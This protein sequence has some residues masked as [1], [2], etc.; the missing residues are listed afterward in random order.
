[1]EKLLHTNTPR[2]A[3]TLKRA[4]TQYLLAD[5]PEVKRD[6]LRHTPGLRSPAVCAI[7]CEQIEAE[8]L[9]ANPADALIFAVNLRLILRFSEP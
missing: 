2:L 4:L 8:L 1:M 9:A 3:D 5:S 7:L 6:L